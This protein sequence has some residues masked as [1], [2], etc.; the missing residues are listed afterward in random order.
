MKKL[1]CLL[2]AV[3]MLLGSMLVLSAC[4]EKDKKK[5]K[6]DTE[7]TEAVIRDLPKVPNGYTQ[8]ENEYVAFVYPTGWSK[9]EIS[10]GLGV[11]L[12]E[13]STGNS[14]S[15]AAEPKSDIYKNMDE[16]SFNQLLKPALE[17]QGLSISGAK[18]S[19]V[20]NAQNFDITKISYT[21]K[22]SGVTLTQVILVIPSG[23]Y[24]YAI[25]VTETKPVEGL[26]DTVFDSIVAKK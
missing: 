26:L 19:Q 24:N 3:T 4:D 6:D 20:K 21:V 8:Y 12:L 7:E 22:A 11:S 23:E 10:G 9:T 1:L 2:L 5:D 25:Y 14:V 13:Q 16:D 15:V 18:V 17:A